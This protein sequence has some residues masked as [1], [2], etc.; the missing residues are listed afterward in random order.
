MLF[1]YT[2]ILGIDNDGDGTV[3]NGLVANCLIGNDSFSTCFGCP[4]VTPNISLAVPPRGARLTVPD[5]GCPD[6]GIWDPTGGSCKTLKR[7][8]PIIKLNNGTSGS[9]TTQT[10][11]G[12]SSIVASLSTLSF[13]TVLVYLAL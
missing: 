9:S 8:V 13:M 3:D 10:S 12:T 6:N 7:P 1:Y 2:H 5:G 11:A 4:T